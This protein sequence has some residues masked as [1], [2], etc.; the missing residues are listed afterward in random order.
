VQCRDGLLLLDGIE[1]SLH[2]KALGDIFPWLVNACREKNVQLF[3]TTQSLEVS[4]AV[5]EACKGTTTGLVA[6]RLEQREN[7]TKATRFDKNTLIGRR[8]E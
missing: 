6:Y 4:D 5:R 8:E 3:A 1:P 7:Q 2:I